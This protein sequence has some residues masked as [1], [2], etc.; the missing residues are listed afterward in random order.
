MTDPRLTELIADLRPRE[1]YN[2]AAM[3]HVG[4]SFKIPRSTFEINAMGAL[5]ALEGAK[6]A[7]AR[8]YQASTSELYG[9]SPAPQNEETTFRPRSP[10]GVSKLAAYWLTVNYR[11]MGLHASNGILFNHESPLRGED[12]VTKK[13]AM[14][15][16]K[17]FHV[18]QGFKLGNLHA[19]RDWGHAK[20]FVKGMWMMLQA[21]PDD[22]VL[23][24]GE[25][26]T[27]KEFLT[28]AF[29]E[30][31]EDWHDWVTIDPKLFRPS[32]VDELCG[33]YTKVRKLGWQPEVTF[34]ELVK[35]M[36]N[37]E[38]SNLDMG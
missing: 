5:N 33:D 27:V 26:H 28:L 25:T 21:P 31:D 34:R 1:V 12:F 10:Y 32:E 38:I 8:F 16:A 30:I 2:L 35:E 11:E 14:G 19:K 24:T 17:V 20:D 3:S 13:I 4:E 22:Y 6:R 18:E 23:A 36:V 9:N 7:N 37:Y 29:K 15:V